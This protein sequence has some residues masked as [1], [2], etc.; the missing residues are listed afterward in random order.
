VEFLGVDFG[1]ADFSFLLVRHRVGGAFH[2]F[3][4]QTETEVHLEKVVFSILLLTFKRVVFD[5]D[6]AG[7]FFMELIVGE[8]EFVSALNLMLRV[9]ESLVETKGFL[10]GDNIAEINFLGGGFT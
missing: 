9:K 5:S 7:D 8:F 1:F 2:R 6:S 10:N 4:T 3:Q